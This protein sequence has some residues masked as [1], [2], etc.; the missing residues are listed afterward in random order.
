MS[1]NLGDLY[2][3]YTNKII[4]D[5]E[6]V[7]HKKKKNKLKKRTAKMKPKKKCKK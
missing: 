4:Y 6:Q 2:W 3:Y 5:N 7:R 1:K